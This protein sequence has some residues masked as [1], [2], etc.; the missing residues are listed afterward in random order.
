MN[1]EITY[2][3][4]QLMVTF[5]HGFQRWLN[6]NEGAGPYIELRESDGDMHFENESQ[7]DEYCEQLKRL[8]KEGDYLE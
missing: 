1:N 7:I 6:L 5:P 3:L 4:N 2:T 8:L